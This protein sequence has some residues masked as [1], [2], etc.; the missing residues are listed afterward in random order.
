[1]KDLAR[2]LIHKPADLPYQ[3]CSLS[4]VKEGGLPKINELEVE[5]PSGSPPQEFSKQ[6]QDEDDG[7][8]RKRGAIWHND[9]HEKFK[10]LTA[11]LRKKKDGKKGICWK[12]I[13]G[14]LPVGK[15][16]QVCPPACQKDAREFC[17]EGTSAADKARQGA[18]AM[19]IASRGARK[20]TGVAD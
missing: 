4:F 13:L 6:K 15:E 3:Y 18:R 14:K 1:M 10:P 8:S 7:G 9:V 19:L 17:N 12:F 11:P 5:M 20:S 16:V 2:K